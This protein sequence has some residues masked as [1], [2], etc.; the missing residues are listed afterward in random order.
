MTGTDTHSVTITIFTDPMMG[1][2]WETEPDFRL[3]EM[4]YEGK[5]NFRYCMSLLVRDV[6]DF[7]LPEE[8]ALDKKEGIKVYNKRLAQIYK[9]EEMIGGM[10]INMLSFHLF[11]D[12][13]TSSLP[14][15][16]AF[17]AVELLS[18][19]KAELF[20][21]CLR[22]ATIVKCRQTTLSREILEVVRELNINEHEFLE[23][24]N[25]GE[26]SL[27]L[28]HDLRC[29]HKMG[30]HSL[31]AYLIQYGDK[32]F[33]INSLVGYPDFE[34][35]ICQITDGKVLSKDIEFSETIMENLIRAR[36]LISSIELYKVF[37]NVDPKQIDKILEKFQKN[38]TV[39]KCEGE[40]DFWKTLEF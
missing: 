6:S 26:A 27:A 38:G 15:N 31:P 23:K 34:S 7:M 5:V 21:Y 35:A 16:L 28:E 1:L 13:H 22:Y 4:H 2:S 12:E 32:G 36:G 14:L 24:F 19:E 40:F 25:H 30:I 39:E 10:P 8:L 17:K 11:D 20:L 37:E 9:S 29:A 18:P 3:M 33:M